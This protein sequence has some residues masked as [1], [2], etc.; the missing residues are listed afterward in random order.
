MCPF[1]LLHF[2]PLGLIAVSALLLKKFSFSLQGSVL[3]VVLSLIGMSSGAHMHTEHAMPMLPLD[4][5]YGYAVSLIVSSANI[6]RSF[7]AN[8]LSVN[9]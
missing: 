2:A 3:V 9:K 5:C 1:E 8:R 7:F 4:P 6:V